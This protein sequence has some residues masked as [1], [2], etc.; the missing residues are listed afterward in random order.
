LHGWEPAETT[1]FEYDGDRLIRTVT[2]RE[3]E[4]DA[5]EVGYLLASRA[6]EFEPKNSLGIPL[7]DALDIAN[8]FKWIPPEAPAIDW[9]AKKLGDAQDAYY[10]KYPDVS[11]NGHM[12][13]PPTL[14]D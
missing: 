12:W 6:I 2:T 5:Q 14:K 11:R 10:K 1:V 9:A 13:R 4:W 8:Q 7:A 3:P